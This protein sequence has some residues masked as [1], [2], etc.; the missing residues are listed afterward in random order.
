MLVQYEMSALEQEHLRVLLLDTRNHVLD[1]A[2]VYRVSVNHVAGLSWRNLQGG[3]PPPCKR[4][5]R[6][7]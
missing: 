5:D 4:A 1:V 7:A 3:D 6:C 2:E